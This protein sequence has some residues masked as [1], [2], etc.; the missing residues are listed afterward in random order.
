[1]PIH[2]LH[3]QVERVILSERPHLPAGLPAQLA[4]QCVFARFQPPPE[5]EPRARTVF[6]FPQCLPGVQMNKHSL[7]ASL[8]RDV[9]AA[10]RGNTPWRDRSLP[11]LQRYVPG[12]EL[13]EQRH[14]DNPAIG[15]YPGI[16]PMP[17]ELLR[18]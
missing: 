11:K 16:P 14:A 3:L 13:P 6:Q 17:A 1:M 18:I 15:R 4:L 7:V 5:V 9:C 8:A 2:T 12:F 10:L